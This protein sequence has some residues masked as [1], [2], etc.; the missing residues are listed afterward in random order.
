MLVVM[1][2]QRVK[3]RVI[4]RRY[5]AAVSRCRKW[6]EMPLNAGRDLRAAPAER[7]PFDR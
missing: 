1:W 7:K 2:S 6:G 5:R 3:R 4:S